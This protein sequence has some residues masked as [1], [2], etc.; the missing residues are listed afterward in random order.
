M[1]HFDV[2]V[3][4]RIHQK[5]FTR[6]LYSL[7]NYFNNICM[8]LYFILISTFLVIALYE[9]IKALIKI[10]VHLRNWIWI[11]TMDRIDFL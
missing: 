11:A 7:N 2:M 5:S 10:E 3:F 9:T 6:Y 1:N 8:S 4:F